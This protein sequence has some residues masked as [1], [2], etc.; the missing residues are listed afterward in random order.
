MGEGYAE[1]R[2]GLDRALS[3]SFVEMAAGVVNPYGCG[4]AARRVAH[5]VRAAPGVSRVK[6]F[7][8]ADPDPDPDK[9]P[10]EQ[11]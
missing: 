8:D 11:A 10:R 1:V 9:E 5:T 2:A 6:P 3:P 4:D 7:V